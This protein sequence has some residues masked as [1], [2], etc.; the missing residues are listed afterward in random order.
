[1]LMRNIRRLVTW[2]GKNI[3]NY[4]RF[5]V[6]L[7]LFSQRLRTFFCLSW[8]PVGIECLCMRKFMEYLIFYWNLIFFCLKFLSHKNSGFSSSRLWMTSNFQYPLTVRKSIKYHSALED[9]NTSR[10]LWTTPHLANFKQ[11]N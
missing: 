2:C 4:L 6:K 11:V 10:H 3:M 8:C 5:L 1:M 9:I 7:N